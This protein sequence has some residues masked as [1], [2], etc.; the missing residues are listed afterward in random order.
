MSESQRRNRFKTITS[1]VTTFPICDEMVR[2][3]RSG[4]CYAL[5]KGISHNFPHPIGDGYKISEVACASCARWQL[6]IEKSRPVK[7][8]VR[9]KLTP[10]CAGW[11]FRAKMA[12]APGQDRNL[13]EQVAFA[14]YNL[15][16]CI[17]PSTFIPK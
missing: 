3:T 14:A 6:K 2:N 5:R 12:S 1:T 9:A 15:Y 17:D 7:A 16:T 4:R 11:Y 8:A 10:P 13:C